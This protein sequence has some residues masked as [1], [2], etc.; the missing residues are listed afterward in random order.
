MELELGVDVLQAQEQEVQARTAHVQEV[1]AVLVDW[2]SA[3]GRQEA[4]GE[5][6]EAHFAV[7]EMQEV[8]DHPSHLPPDRA[9]LARLA[10]PLTARP[11]PLPLQGR[12]PGP[13]GHQRR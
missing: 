5:A 2:G 1:L 13:A 9:A 4:A 7:Q 12:R 8:Q 11:R 10:R 6:V 3:K